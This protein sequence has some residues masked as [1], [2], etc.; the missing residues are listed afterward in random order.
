M[1]C[2]AFTAVLGI[3]LFALPAMAAVPKEP[4]A[5]SCG[6]YGTKVEFLESPQV[7]ATKALKQ[8]KLVFILHV[9]GIFEDPRFT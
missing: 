8:E 7:A 9:S 6:K 1:R 4:S 3:G 2:L 5:D